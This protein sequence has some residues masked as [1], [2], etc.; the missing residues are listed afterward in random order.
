MFYHSNGDTY[1]GYFRANKANGTGTFKH[2]KTGARYEGEWV[3]DVQHGTGKEYQADG[4]FYHGQF[5]QGAKHGQ[6]TYI[7]ADGTKY[8]GEY[9]NNMMSCGTFTW[10]DGRVYTGSWQ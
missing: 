3:D 8:E 7:G 4:S 10:P 1:E 2:K 9:S 5:Y 6:G